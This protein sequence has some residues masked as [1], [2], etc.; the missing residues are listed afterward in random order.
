VTCRALLLLFPALL[1]A[2]PDPFP[3]PARN[4]PDRELATKTAFVLCHRATLKVP[5]WTADELKPNRQ[6]NPPRPKQFHK[7]LNLTHEGA[8]NTDYTNGGYSR[9]HMVPAEDMTEPA[10]TFLLS[11]TV[12]QNQS[13]N[14][15]IWRQ[16]ENKI[17]KLAADAD[18]VYVITGT[19]FD[20][21][22]I[23]LIGK[24]KVAVPTHLYKVILVVQGDS[25]SVY[26]A[27]IPNQPSARDPLSTYTVTLADLENRTGLRFSGPAPDLRRLRRASNPRSIQRTRLHHGDR[28]INRS[29]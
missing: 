15:G 28:T 3:L 17:R 24:G 22:Q 1:T 29:R 13:M 16:L 6:N 8:S 19:I 20:P 9:G 25:K 5:I 11:N 26:A 12:P 27:I 23:E 18:A 2:Q 7:D 14:A 21:P 4:G 10:D